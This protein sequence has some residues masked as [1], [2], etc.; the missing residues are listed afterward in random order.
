MNRIAL[1]MGNRFLYWSSLIMTLG[2]VSA[3]LM[4]LAL[5]FGEKKNHLASMAAVPLSALLSLLLSRFVHWYC[6]PEVYESLSAAMLNFRR[7]GFALIGVFGGCILA[8]VILRLVRLSRNLPGMLDHMALAGCL[9][10]AAGRLA[11]FFNTTDRGMPLPETVGLPW[12]VG[13]T[14]EVAGTAENRL[15]IFIIQAAVAAL[16]F[17]GLTVFYFRGRKK[18]TLRDG[19]TCL[20]FLLIY[21]ASQI[22]LDSPRYDNLYFRS[23]GFVTIVQIFSLLALLTVATIF[24]VRLAKKR[25]A[26]WASMALLLLPLLGCA[27]YMEYHVQRHG[28]QAALAYSLMAGCLAIAV[29][30]IL[31]IR[32]FAGDGVRHAV[33]AAAP[34]SAVPQTE[35]EEELISFSTFDSCDVPTWSDSY[36]NT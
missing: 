1:I 4:F 6:R 33:S 10:I 19:D 35:D 11:S 17:A 24:T 15:A 30:R 7:G 36:D 22:V 23:N 21:C 26:R 16:L 18:Q 34:S 31:V 32:G 2:G 28:D 20:I 9:G 29:V 27:G 5:E 14:N 25:G 13:M 12:A 8:A 3:A